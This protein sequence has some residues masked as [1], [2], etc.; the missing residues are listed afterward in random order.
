MT[1]L[2]IKRIYDLPSADDGTRVLVDRLWPRGISKAD[3]QLDEWYKEIA[4]TTELRKWFGHDRDNWQEF[5]IRYRQELDANPDAVEHLCA[6]AL[7]ADMTLLYA[8]HDP[9]INHAHVLEQYLREHC[10]SRTR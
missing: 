8:A 3:A 2:Q 5:Q 9:V 1:R 10:Q 4:P 7:K 6:V